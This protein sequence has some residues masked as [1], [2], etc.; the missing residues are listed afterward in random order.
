MSLGRQEAST[1]GFLYGGA[2]EQQAGSVSVRISLKVFTSC[3]ACAQAVECLSR[4]GHM[5]WVYAEV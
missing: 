4:W 3:E 5:L 2:L 1:R